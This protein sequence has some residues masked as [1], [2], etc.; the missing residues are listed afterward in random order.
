MTPWLRK[1]HKWVG[2]IIAIQFVLWLG[3]GLVMSLLDHDTVQGHTHRAHAP[4]PAFAWP[5]DALAPAVVL[6]KAGREVQTLETF[7]LDGR[8][9]YR[10][11]QQGEV[12][13]LDAISGAPVPVNADVALSIAQKDY[14]GDGKA[15]TPELQSTADL[16]AREHDGA[17]WRIPFSD[18]EATTLY[19][20]A[21]DGRVLERRNDT[22]R[23]FDVVWM[24]HIMDYTG[25]QNF[26][27]PL[28]VTAAV[29]GV[30]MALT[31][32]WLLFASFRL[33]EFVP[34]RWR[35]PRALSVYAPDGSLLRSVDARSGDNVYVALARNGLQLPSNCG[36][37]QSCGLCE[38]RFRGQ[39]PDPTSADRTHLGE[40]KLKQGYRLACNLPVQADMGVE[41][42]GGAAIWSEH[43]ATVERVT[44]ITPFLREIVIRPQ[45]PGKL[46]IAPG[47]YVQVHIPQ[48]SLT[49][50]DLHHPEHHRDEWRALD[51]PDAIA[52][53]EPV[54]RSYSLA[55]PLKQADGAI[56]L[57]ARFSPG[58]QDRKRHPP[59][60][61]SSYLYS[62]REGDALRFSGPFGDFKLKP[63]HAEKVFIGGGAGMA[64][65]RS[66]IH[67]L[68]DGG[69]K[70]RIHFWYGARNLR[71]APYLEE[72][73]ELA[74]RHSNFSWHL[75][76]SEEA[77]RSAG[78][79]KG[80]V[81]EASHEGLLRDHPDL[82]A[83]EFYLCGP[84]AM[85]SATRQLLSRLGVTDDRVA[86]DDFKI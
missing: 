72:M 65:L 55:M 5:G 69:A 35:R 23:L 32:I 20:S 58:R 67:A 70:E 18:E 16:E 75:V 78:L 80:L 11:S 12:W 14:S 45:S 57:L 85:L 50:D 30:W 60:K 42:P 29:G 3:S 6:A 4:A 64:P 34:S 74:E 54:R 21:Q 25:R 49:R 76:L 41:V 27:N 79:V 31:G 46:D 1:L 36:G 66:M 81:H 17:I 77:E 56:T 63:G 73:A 40:A 10:L 83:C 68:L 47:A 84:P 33:G 86:F 37:G 2:L 51:M 26:N 39:A 59:G 44:P 28:V 13:L 9:V 38:V 82:H 62:L 8:A 61:G 15:G 22:W 7:Q 48:Y 19:V 52:S 43:L 53:R 71:D 24:L